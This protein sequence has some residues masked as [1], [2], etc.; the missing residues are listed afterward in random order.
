MM[1]EEVLIT[2]KHF[3]MFHATIAAKNNSQQPQRLPNLTSGNKRSRR[4]QFSDWSSKTL[5]TILIAAKDSAKVKFRAI[6]QS[7]DLKK[8]FTNKPMSPFYLQLI[9]QK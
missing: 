7:T 5:D 4:N 1:W 2:L 6:S 8:R 3:S 9:L